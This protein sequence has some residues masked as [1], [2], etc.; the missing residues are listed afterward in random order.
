M[1]ED[2]FRRL[3]IEVRASCSIDITA[4]DGTK[5]EMNY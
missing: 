2:R 4:V 3:A 5:D 1:P